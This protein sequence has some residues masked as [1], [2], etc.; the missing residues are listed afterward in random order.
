MPNAWEDKNWAAYKERYSID[1][2]EVI[3]ATEQK[4]GKTVPFNN[5]SYFQVYYM[6]GKGFIATPES[7]P[8]FPCAH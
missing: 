3:K 1:K 7:A 2:F 4:D 8:A 5:F 6:K